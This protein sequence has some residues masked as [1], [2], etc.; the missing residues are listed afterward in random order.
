[1]AKAFYS[2]T[3]TR[4]VVEQITIEEIEAE[5]EDEAE[6]LAIEYAKDESARRWNV[7]DDEYTIDSVEQ[8][9]EADPNVTCGACDGHGTAYGETCVTCGGKGEVTAEGKYIEA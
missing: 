6:C 2:V 5:N 3:V 1:M 7:M 9:G 8:T 4:V